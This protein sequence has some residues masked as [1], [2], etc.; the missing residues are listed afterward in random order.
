[1]ALPG[2]YTVSLAQRVDGEVT[3]LA[4]PMSFRI[5]PI[6]EPAIAAQ[7]RDAVLAFQR[8][9]GELLRAVTGSQ[10][11]AAAAA[12]R[13][14]AIKQALQR[15]PA[16]PGALMTEARALELRL[17][18]LRETLEGSR[19]RSSRA[20]PDLPG[21]TGRVN[22]IVRGHWNGMHGPTGTHREQYRVAREAFGA[23]YPDLA[24][25][26]ETDLPA[27]EASLEAAGVPW[28]T[29]RALPRWPPGL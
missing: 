6:N 16:A 21:I 27:L 8:E 2:S 19:T 24:R 12:A 5:A 18:D 10:R 7:D 26:V 14:A 17:L 13:I 25:L 28:T 15:W 11:V 23:L 4:G 22:Q 20:E 29:G 9:T 3:D 1:M